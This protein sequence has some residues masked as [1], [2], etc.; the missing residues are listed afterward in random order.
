M[1]EFIALTVPVGGALGGGSAEW[2]RRRVGKVR[3]GTSLENIQINRL[4]KPI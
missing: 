3:E 2:W 4:G 1:K